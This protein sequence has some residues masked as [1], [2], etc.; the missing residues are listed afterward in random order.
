MSSLKNLQTIHLDFNHIILIDPEIFKRCESLLEVY[1]NT[2]SSKSMKQIQSKLI[3]RNANI[4]LEAITFIC[5]FTEPEFLLNSVEACQK[6]DYISYFSNHQKLTLF[7]S[8]SES[9]QNI[10][11][12]NITEGIGYLSQNYDVHIN[13]YRPF[14]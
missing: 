8:I 12:K 2:T 14:R 5:G 13:K 9:D 4:F 10:L 7:Q 3:E 11:I 1:C 6:L